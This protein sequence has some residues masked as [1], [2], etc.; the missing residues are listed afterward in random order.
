MFATRGHELPL[1]PLPTTPDGSRILV[2]DALKGLRRLCSGEKDAKDY[3]HFARNH[4]KIALDRLNYIPK[5]GGSRFSLPP[6]LEL[7]CHKGKKGYPDVYGRMKWEDVA[8]T[9]TTGCTDLTKGRFAHPEDDRAITLREA[10]RLQTFH[11]QEGQS[12]KSM[13]LCSVS[14][15]PLG[16]G[17]RSTQADD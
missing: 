16:L 8:P 13:A 4:K 7:D 3:L 12:P 6:H 1:P 5:N 10:A 11:A 17:L 14:I 15:P 9:L 2:Q